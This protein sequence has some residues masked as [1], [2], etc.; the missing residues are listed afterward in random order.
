VAA[1]HP[2]A[3]PENW[4]YVYDE[5][6]YTTRINCTE[7]LSPNNAP[8]GKTGIQVEVYFSKYKPATESPERIAAKV[9]SE[10]VEMGLI[11]SLEAITAV[12]TKFVPWANVIF[13]H[14]RR[15]ALD[16]VLDWLSQKGLHREDDDLEPITDWET[17]LAEPLRPMRASRYFLQVDTPSGSTTGLMTVCFGGFTFRRRL[18][19][20]ELCLKHVPPH[21]S[22]TPVSEVNGSGSLA[23]I[24]LAGL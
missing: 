16:Q 6:K 8:A 24:A 10:L 5:D 17:K 11:K 23:A 7:L 20:D 12:H 4:I 13:D 19:G 22:G 15:G 2:T 3:R 1:D 9:C 21:V 14:D 18:H